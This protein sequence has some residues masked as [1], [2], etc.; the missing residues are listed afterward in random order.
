MDSLRL[1]RGERRPYGRAFVIRFMSGGEFD[2]V[3]LSDADPALVED[4]TVNGPLC[5]AIQ[6]SVFPQVVE[7]SCPKLC[8]GNLFSLPDP[9]HAS[10]RY[11]NRIRLAA[12]STAPTLLAPQSSRNMYSG[13]RMRS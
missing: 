9:V 3:F 2:P 11:R 7:Q 4:G 12:I 8:R 13:R 1:A 10:A 6:G 5:S